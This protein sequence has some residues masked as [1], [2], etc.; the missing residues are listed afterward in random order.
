V[1]M[2]LK[3]T[4]LEDDLV[5]VGE[6]FLKIAQING[7]KNIKIDSAG[8]LI[9]ESK[10]TIVIEPC[11]SGEIERV[12]GGFLFGGGKFSVQ[13]ASLINQVI[14]FSGPV[15]INQKHS[16]P[17]DSF[18]N[19]QREKVEKESPVPQGQRLTPD[20]Q[21]NIALNQLNRGNK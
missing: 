17:S 8:R 5:E 12:S 14:T 18:R 4:L 15:T 7:R 3:L 21:R 20:Q 19:K 6:S 2:G 10:K 16:N 1:N 13:L 11:G 9:I